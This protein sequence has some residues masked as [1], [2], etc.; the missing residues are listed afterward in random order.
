MYVMANESLEGQGYAAE[1]ESKTQNT[2]RLG[3]QEQA[4][5][6]WSLGSLPLS[7]TRTAGTAGTIPILN[8]TVVC[9]ASSSSTERLANGNQDDGNAQCDIVIYFAHFGMT[10]GMFRTMA[11]QCLQ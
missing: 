2:T 7:A 3:C 6:L 9:L 10:I 1:C 5:A 8:T 4:Q 11:L